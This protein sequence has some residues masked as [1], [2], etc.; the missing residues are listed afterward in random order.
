MKNHAL[1]RLAPWSNERS[2]PRT[3][4]GA[5]AGDSDIK[6]FHTVKAAPLAHRGADPF[7]DL[8]PIEDRLLSGE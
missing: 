5:G 8:R 7:I 6:S 1:N 3:A 2:G 4:A